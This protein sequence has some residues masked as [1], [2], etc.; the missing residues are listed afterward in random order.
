[1]H[2]ENLLQL[3]DEVAE[4][5]DQLSEQVDAARASRVCGFA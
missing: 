3:E 2:E 5:H 4:E 1:M